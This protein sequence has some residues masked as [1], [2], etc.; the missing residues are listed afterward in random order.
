M[1]KKKRTLYEC[2][3]ARVKGQEIYCRQGY[4]LSRDKGDGSLDIQ[5]LAEGHH[6]IDGSLSALRGFFKVGNGAGRRSAGL[7]QKR[8]GQAWES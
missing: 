6:L 3:H 5:W 1:I 2:A 4:P 7:A 8:G